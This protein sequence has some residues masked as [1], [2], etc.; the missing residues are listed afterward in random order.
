MRT[1][2]RAYWT[3]KAGNE[4]SEYQDAFAFESWDEGYSN[5]T[6]QRFVVADGATEAIYSGPWARALAEN[7]YQRRLDLADGH[8]ETLDQLAA[9]WQADLPVISRPW[10]A[11]EKIESGSF[12]TL[13]GLALTEKGGGIQWEFQA[14]GDSCLFIVQLGK[15]IF[16]GPIKES[17]QFSSSPYLVGTQKIHNKNLAR[18]IVIENGILDSRDDLN[19]FLMTDAIACWFMKCLESGESPSIL[20]RISDGPDEQSVFL[21]SIDRIR[22]EGGMRNDDVTLLSVS[23]IC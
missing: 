23:V 11:E 10:W 1:H 15:L 12:S 18:E 16:C 3:P 13:A 9:Q 4:E 14:V 17:S 7:W 19:F 21:A 22:D 6:H 20:E 2:T 5:E 8:E